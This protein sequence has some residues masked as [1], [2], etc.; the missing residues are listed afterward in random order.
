MT[1]RRRLLPRRVGLGVGVGMSA[2]VGRCTIAARGGSGE[3]AAATSSLEEKSRVVDSA[4]RRSRYPGSLEHAGV[5]SSNSVRRH[6]CDPRTR[7]SC[8]G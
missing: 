8:G 1:P 3:V 2:E 6:E 7:V 4:G 5:A